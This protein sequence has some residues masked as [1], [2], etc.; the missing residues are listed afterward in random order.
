[1]TC[2][3]FPMQEGICKFDACVL[4]CLSNVDK[5]AFPRKLL[6]VFN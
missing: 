4:V 2:F 6:A 1:M 5:L 3:N